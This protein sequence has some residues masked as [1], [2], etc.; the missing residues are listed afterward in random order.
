[1]TLDVVSP[2][3]IK[4][5]VTYLGH[6]TPQS[7]QTHAPRRLPGELI[8][9]TIHPLVKGAKPFFGLGTGLVEGVYDL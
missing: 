9:P 5:S 7:S 8:E 1:M 3:S 6:M 2:P 4:D